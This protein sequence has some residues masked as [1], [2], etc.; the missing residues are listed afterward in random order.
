MIL[1]KKEKKCLRDLTTFIEGGIK[2][3]LITQILFIIIQ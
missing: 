3:I 1:K 2:L